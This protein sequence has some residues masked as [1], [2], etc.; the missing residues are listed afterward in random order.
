VPLRRK[1]ESGI[2]M[3]NSSFSL[4]VVLYL[5]VKIKGMRQG[6]SHEMEIT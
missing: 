6:Y 2:V 3:M 5:K 4:T 1:A